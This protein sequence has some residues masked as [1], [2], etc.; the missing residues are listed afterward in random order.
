MDPVLRCVC[1]AIT[2]MPKPNMWYQS[3]VR[4]ILKQGKVILILFVRDLCSHAIKM[5]GFFLF[6][7]SVLSTQVILHCHSAY[8]LRTFI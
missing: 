5:K 3:S 4:L 8:S 2:C 6:S 1:D 7:G